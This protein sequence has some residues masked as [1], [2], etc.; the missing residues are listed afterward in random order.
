MLTLVI[1]LSAFSVHAPH[2]LFV[3]EEL[4][5]ALCNANKHCESIVRPRLSTSCN[6]HRKPKNTPENQDLIKSYA[7]FK[8][9]M[10]N[11]VYLP[12]LY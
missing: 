10:L 4:P 12:L 8:S 11:Y 1:S 6:I 5:K 3:T 9:N 2:V 7:N